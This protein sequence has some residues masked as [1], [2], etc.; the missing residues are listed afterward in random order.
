MTQIGTRLEAFS[1]K[2]DVAQS[3]IR[4]A[5]TAPSVR[6]SAKHS[7]PTKQE[8]LN[9]NLLSPAKD[10]SKSTET[11]PWSSLPAMLLSPGK[12]MDQSN[13]TA[14]LNDKS[15]QLYRISTPLEKHKSSKTAGL[16]PAKST[17][18]SSK[19]L[20]QL[21]GTE[22]QEWSKGGGMKEINELRELL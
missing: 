3:N 12:L 22:K 18:K 19:P 6:T 8:N 14:Q 20:T 4:E 13:G 9:I 17:A 15:L 16:M 2:Q 21:S 10:K 1:P 5:V 11:I 7:S